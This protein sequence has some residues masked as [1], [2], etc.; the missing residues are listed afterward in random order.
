MNV[1]EL[2]LQVKRQYG[3]EYGV[4][5]TDQD[6]LQ[7]IYEGE[8][9]IIR[10]TSGNAIQAVPSVQ[11][12]QFPIEIPANI[13]VVRVI[14]NEQTPHVLDYITLNELDLFK[15]SLQ[16]AK[17]P[18]KYWFMPNTND[19]SF[20]PEPR[21][22]DIDL[23]PRDSSLTTLVA[24]HFRQTATKRATVTGE[25]TIPERHHADLLQFCLARCHNKNRDAQ[26][27]QQAMSYYDKNLAMRRDENTS[28]DGVNYKQPDPADWGY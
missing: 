12:K 27:E 16:G 14:T 18:P 20:S 19:A 8:M 13:Q 11:V 1:S 23:Y 17:G 26:S 28:P 4:V 21:P 10:S 24:V 5:I 7:F 22:W 3:D 15:V 6:I 9:D 2:V 25:L